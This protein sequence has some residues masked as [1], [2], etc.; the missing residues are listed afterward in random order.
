MTSP[1]AFFNPLHRALKNEPSLLHDGT[2]YDGKLDPDG[3]TVIVE[4][5]SIAPFP[6]NE[7][8]VFVSSNGVPLH[9]AAPLYLHS[10]NSGILTVQQMLS[11]VEQMEDKTLQTHGVVTMHAQLSPH[12][13][14]SDQAYM[15]L[16]HGIALGEYTDDAN[17][18]ILPH[19]I[20]CALDIVSD[21]ERATRFFT[22]LNAAIVRCNVH[23]VDRLLKV[24]FF[25]YLAPV[26]APSGSGEADQVVETTNHILFRIHETLANVL[27]AYRWCTLSETAIVDYTRMWN[28]CLDFVGT[29]VAYTSQPE[30]TPHMM[31]HK[32][33]RNRFHVTDENEA[34][35][36]IYMAGGISSNLFRKLLLF[37]PPSWAHDAFAMI[38]SSYAK[39]Y[40][41][42]EIE[43]E[44]KCVPIFNMWTSHNVNAKDI[45]MF[46]KTLGAYLTKDVPVKGDAW[47]SMVPKLSH[48]INKDEIMFLGVEK[49][50]QIR[51]RAFA[52]F[53]RFT[54]K[55]RVRFLSWWEEFLVMLPPFCAHLF[56][57]PYGAYIRDEWMS[58]HATVHGDST[59][60]KRDEVI[61]TRTKWLLYRFK[62]C[63]IDKVLQYHEEIDDVDDTSKHAMFAY[64][65]LTSPRDTAH[66]ALFDLDRDVRT[67]VNDLWLARKAYDIIHDTHQ[68]IHTYD[69]EHELTMI[70]NKL[71]EHMSPKLVT[72]CKN[73]HA[74][75]SNDPSR[76]ATLLWYLENDGELVDVINND[77]DASLAL[78]RF[79]IHIGFSASLN[80]VLAVISTNHQL[81]MSHY[82]TLICQ[83]VENL[84]YMRC[85]RL[86]YVS[87]TAKAMTNAKKT[88]TAPVGLLNATTDADDV[89]VELAM[90]DV[91]D[92]EEE[93]EEAE[94]DE[95]GDGEDDEEDDGEGDEEEDA[96]EEV[97]EDDETYTDDDLLSFP[98]YPT[99]NT[100]VVLF[101]HAATATSRQK[102]SDDDTESYIQQVSGYIQWLSLP[103]QALFQQQL[104]TF[105]LSHPD[106]VLY[107][108]EGIKKLGGL[109]DMGFMQVVAFLMRQKQSISEVVAIKLRYQR[110]SDL[111]SL[112]NEPHKVTPV[113]CGLLMNEQ[114]NATQIK[115][116]VLSNETLKNEN[117]CEL[118]VASSVHNFGVIKSVWNASVIHKSWLLSSS[119]KS[120]LFKTS[121][122]PVCYV[123]WKPI[124]IVPTTFLVACHACYCAQR[125]V[126]HF[127]PPTF[128]DSPLCGIAYLHRETM[129]AYTQYLDQT[130]RFGQSN[131]SD[132]TPDVHTSW[133]DV[134]RGIVESQ[135]VDLRPIDASRAATSKVI[136]S[137][138]K[139]IIRN[140]MVQLAL[141]LFASSKAYRQSKILTLVIESFDAYRKWRMSYTGEE[142]PVGPPNLPASSASEIKDH[143]VHLEVLM[144]NTS[145][146]RPH[147]FGAAIP[148]FGLPIDQHKR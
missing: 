84:E 90:R 119:A 133:L 139:N 131:G 103:S 77:L 55:Y 114:A 120:Q 123:D 87:R 54:H 35:N 17:D 50:V 62:S 78:V 147:Q 141:Q 2:P 10:D 128:D 72:F 67:V 101:T 38:R 43:A 70:H 75:Q 37:A 68:T 112:Q 11:Q 116:C 142:E 6:G 53:V 143:V 130:R 61:I 82:V 39:R 23:V 4:S 19:R 95:E 32:P 80:H 100:L 31:S 83:A 127:E 21:R 65:F 110:C 92:G 122:N 91:N 117:E 102:I 8:N 107:V 99:P 129:A 22:L 29:F 64:L 12:T 96:D 16:R 5:A 24:S 71:Y 45:M 76:D 137:Y 134:V 3:S 59:N 132:V 86:R 63:S 27:T 73:A 85:P 106:K 7:L 1:S 60:N 66:Q 89:P 49:T 40:N 145:I 41:T 69:A 93:K 140:M 74:L 79:F 88:I 94:D 111:I 135:C 124:G 20:H 46:V 26:A 109:V 18:A 13:K 108:N 81:E 14:I 118:A 126:A 121:L 104:M 148:A 57:E 58:T 47:N 30:N 9:Q 97:D 136:T 48:M 28:T 15:Q 33:S 115:M 44:A 52:Q 25:H 36:I 138:E 42:T 98:T 105:V 34:S 51:P 146:N 144:Q 113:T 56:Y 125:I